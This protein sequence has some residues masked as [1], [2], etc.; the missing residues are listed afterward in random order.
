MKAE[1]IIKIENPVVRIICS[2]KQFSKL[3]AT[4]IKFGSK[5]VLKSTG[6]TVEHEMFIVSAIRQETL[7]RVRTH[8]STLLP[9][10]IIH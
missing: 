2:E 5:A 6:R 8:Q 10:S 7:F 3:T 9:V 4:A 1:E